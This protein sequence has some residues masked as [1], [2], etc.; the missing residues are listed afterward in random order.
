MTGTDEKRRMTALLFVHDEAGPSR[1]DGAC[2]VDREFKRERLLGSN[3]AERHLRIPEHVI[4]LSA[5]GARRMEIKVLLALE[6]R[7]HRNAVGVSGL[8]HG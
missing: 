5:Q 6:H 3:E 8:I 4:G 1:N 2:V 7:A